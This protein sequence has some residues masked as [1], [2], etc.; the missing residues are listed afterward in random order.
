[1]INISIEIDTPI[2]QKVMSSL[3]SSESERGYDALS[4]EMLLSQQVN[5][6]DSVSLKNMGVLERRSQCPII[7]Y[8][9]HRRFSG[10]GGEL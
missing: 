7:V 1:M 8:Y 10:G 2:K 3:L 5:M 4:K 6:P 9:V